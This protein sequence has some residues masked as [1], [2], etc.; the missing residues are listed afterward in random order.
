MNGRNL[1]IVAPE[2]S[3]TVRRPR[4]VVA[5][6]GRVRRLARFVGARAELGVAGSLPGAPPREVADSLR[7]P[8]PSA[9]IFVAT[10]ATM[11]YNFKKITTVRAPLN[12]ARVSS[13]PPRA[14]RGD[15]RPATAS[16]RRLGGVAAGPIGAKPV[17]ARLADERRP[18]RHPRG[19]P[20]SK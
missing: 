1:C 16:S 19:E 11:Q 7:G 10:M 6:A 9:G 14:R 17:V 2:A 13:S 12:F 20:L 18:P 4:G 3:R 8:A 15:G 5:D